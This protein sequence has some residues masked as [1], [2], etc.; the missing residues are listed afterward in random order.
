MQQDQASEAIHE[1]TQHMSIEE[2]QG[3]EEHEHSAEQGLLRA[4]SCIVCKLAATWLI[5]LATNTTKQCL[6]LAECQNGYLYELRHARE[7]GVGV[8]KV[9]Q[10]TSHFG[11]G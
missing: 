1:G 4:S 6:L 5:P 2:S 11:K 3:V 8:C 9:L 7:R 10:F